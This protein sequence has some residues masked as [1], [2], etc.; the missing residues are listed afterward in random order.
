MGAM[1]TS[2]P[3]LDTIK[4]LLERLKANDVAWFRERY[5]AGDLAW[6]K[7]R[8]PAGGY[9]KLGERIEAGD[10]GW[11][12]ERIAT[13]PG[14]NIPGLDLGS[15]GLGNVGSVA[16]VGGAAAGAAT[17]ALKGAASLGTA[18]AGAAAAA[19][20]GRKR[21]LWF[22]PIV[23][24]AAI[25]AAL[26]MKQCNKDDTVATDSEVAASDASESA[27]PEST[28]TETTAAMGSEAMASTAATT[29]TTVAAAPASE[30]GAPAAGGD[31]V[32]TAQAAGNFST[33][34]A[35]IGAAGLTETLQGP[36]PFTVFAPTDEAFAKLPPG[37]VDALLKPENKPILEQILKYHVVGAK[38]PAADVKTGPAKSVEGSDLDLVSAD[39]KVT[40]NG[41]N[42]TTADVAASNGLIHVIDA[43]L[44]PKSVDVAALL[45]GAATPATEAAAPTTAA[46]AAPSTEPAAAPVNAAGD[47]VSEDLTVYFANASAAINAEGKAKI[48]KAVT[49]L[50]AVPAGTKVNVVGHA[51]AVGDPAKNQK[52][53]ESRANNVIAALK[54]GL[55]AKASNVEFTASAEGDKNP[56]ENADKSRRVTVEIQK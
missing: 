55:G 14:M 21:G 44:I 49:T 53:S 3:P 37:A 46:A 23:L 32:A 25:A 6:L 10:L 54:A 24:L 15:M 26:L 41:A 20:G 39:G 16:N 8:L 19:V 34:T 51:S 33:L 36:G 9:E 48:A 50:S 4:H 5:K 30:A 17:G 1:S 13:L 42:V 27:A 7:D 35:A 11:L 47:A 12:R 22:I 40:V 45:G 56:V 52:L 38:V 29:E 43:V 28:A 31:I 18:G 2:L